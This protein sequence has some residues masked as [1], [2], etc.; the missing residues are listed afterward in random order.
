M[1]APTTATAYG[2]DNPDEHGN[3]NP[4]SA[5]VIVPGGHAA[6][7]VSDHFPVD[8]V[9]LPGGQGDWAKPG[10]HVTVRRVQLSHIRRPGYNRRAVLAARLAMS[11]LASAATIN[12]E[13]LRRINPVWYW[14]LR[15]SI[16]DQRAALVLASG[17][18]IEHVRRDGYD[19]S[20]ADS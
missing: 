7:S 4:T 12:G 8:V 15:T 5:E 1:T 17:I 20:R 13:Q 3:R 16:D 10:L 9:T 11:G 18:P 2:A 14:D 6:L 19:I